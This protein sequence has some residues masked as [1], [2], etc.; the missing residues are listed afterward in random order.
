[1]YSR[2]L[3]NATGMDRSRIDGSTGGRRGFGDTTAE[4][5]DLE[6]FATVRR[7]QWPK[8]FELLCTSHADYMLS[9]ARRY[10]VA[11]GVHSACDI[12]QEYLIALFLGFAENRFTLPHHHLRAYLAIG[13]HQMGCACRRRDLGRLASMAPS[14]GDATRLDPADPHAEARFGH[15]E[16]MTRVAHALARLRPVY[17]E[18]LHLRCVERLRHA[19]I[20]ER[21]GI[22]K[23]TVRTLLPRARE[24]L[25]IALGLP[26][27]NG[28]ERQRVARAS[29]RKPSDLGG[30]TTRDS[31]CANPAETD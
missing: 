26:K 5:F 18:V 22:P 30:S 21:M 4:D 2:M 17:L 9:V 24:E 11:G 1:M 14:G 16:A 10:V 7:A 31:A 3:R 6:F 25:R 15:T 12:V 13:L 23:A 20:A 28:N 29:L 8:A 19:Q 27:E